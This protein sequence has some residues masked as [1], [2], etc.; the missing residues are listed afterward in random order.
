[1]RSQAPQRLYREAVAV[2]QQTG[3]VQFHDRQQHRLRLDTQPIGQFSGVDRPDRSRP[4]NGKTN[5]VK[6]Q[7]Q[8]IRWV[9][10]GLA[11][12]QNLALWCL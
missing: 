7:T 8:V 9:D 5:R 10:H 2:I 6:H 12:Y 4:E 11:E 1:L 3:F